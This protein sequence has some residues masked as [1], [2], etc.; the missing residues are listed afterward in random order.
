MLSK[1]HRDIL[2]GE[3]S[4]MVFTRYFLHDIF[5]SPALSIHIYTETFNFLTDI[6]LT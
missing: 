2:A 3:L 6:K 5:T 1:I 4:D